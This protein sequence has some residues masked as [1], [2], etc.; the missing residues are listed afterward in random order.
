MI[1][2]SEHY[3]L[4]LLNWVDYIQGV[5]S[6]GNVEPASYCQCLVEGGENIAAR[7]VNRRKVKLA[8]ARLSLT[9]GM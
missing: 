9:C 6:E 3:I 5:A 7:V 8:V 1:P 4:S 2:P